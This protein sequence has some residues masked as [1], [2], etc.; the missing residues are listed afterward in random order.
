MKHIKLFEQF[1][2]ESFERD[3]KEEIKLT[4][5]QLDIVMRL[6]DAINTAMNNTSVGAYQTGTIQ[7]NYSA[8]VNDWMDLEVYG[9]GIRMWMEQDMQIRPIFLEIE[10]NT[11]DELKRMVDLGLVQN[12]AD[13]IEI[14]GEYITGFNVTTSVSYDSKDVS[15]S[16]DETSNTEFYS[17]SY[18]NFNDNGPQEIE[19]LADDIGDWATEWMDESAIPESNIQ[20]MLDEKFPE[21]DEDEDDG[22]ENENDEDD[23]DD[24]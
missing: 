23:D 12:L 4:E 15:F 17:A 20:A 5:H 2:S 6:A 10:G 7:F 22:D 3:P 16:Y 21:D 24:Y 13:F 8:S 18:L 9:D 19:R 11:Q 1:V 14:E